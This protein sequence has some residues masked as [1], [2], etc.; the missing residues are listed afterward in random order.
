MNS[1]QWIMNYRSA[2]VGIAVALGAAI[3]IAVYGDDSTSSDVPACAAKSSDLGTAFFGGDP[4]SNGLST[5]VLLGNA[6]MTNLDAIKVMVETPLRDFSTHPELR[7]QLDDEHAREFMQYLVS[8]ALGQGDEVTGPPRPPAESPV[9]WK[10]WSGL[11]PQWLDEKADE[12]CQEVVSA[13]LLA[14]NNAVGE[15]KVPISVRGC[16]ADDS[17]LGSSSV[18]RQ[19]KVREAAFYGNM[20]SAKSLPYQVKVQ[21]HKGKWDI[22]YTMPGLQGYVSMAEW[23]YARARA[24]GGKTSPPQQPG[25]LRT[26]FH[27]HVVKDY[28]VKYSGKSPGPIFV[29]KN[30][31][32]CWDADWTEGNAY[33]LDRVCGLD[34]TAQK[35]LCAA[36]P[37]GPCKGQNE[38]GEV[39][40]MCGKEYRP[41]ARYFDFDD[42]RDD[43]GKQWKYPL[44]VFLRE[45]CVIVGDTRSCHRKSG[46]VA[47]NQAYP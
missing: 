3:G 23:Q 44:T 11:C 28:I 22:K 7:I 1:K 10:G 36:V 17:Y 18:A 12:T 33:S 9:T 43:S 35:H 41:P 32:S 30:M 34:K 39:K 45:P 26:Q 24:R 38:R 5:E 4:T 6:L 16:N 42:C 13:C 46:P 25:T 31:Y 15:K 29:H 8:C 19:Y 20:F 47:D 27:R 2:W 21:K 14:R 40:Q 37:V